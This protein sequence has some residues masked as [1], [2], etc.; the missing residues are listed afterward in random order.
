VAELSARYLQ[1]QLQ[2]Y[3]LGRVERSHRTDDEEFY[4][5]YLLQAHN[6]EQFLALSY[7]WLYVY[8]VLRPHFGAG[9]EQRPPL[10]ALRHWGYTGD[11]HIAL[12]PPILLDPIS[13]DLLLSCDKQAGN[14]LLATYIPCETFHRPR[15]AQERRR[16][17]GSKL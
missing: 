7:R 2:R 9:M 12:L 3:P 6:T 11:E 15:R 8:N 17:Q 13:T 4:A 16:R 14:D 1:G 5:P 10:A